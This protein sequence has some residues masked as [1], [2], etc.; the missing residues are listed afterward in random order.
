MNARSGP[1]TVS[2]TPISRV[3]AAC[4][5]GTTI[6]FYDFFIYG[7]AAA[8]VFPK[9]FFPEASPFLGTVLA[10]A[11]FG[12]GFVARPLGG[13][14]FGHFGDRLGRKK[15]LILS[16]MIMGVSTVL[17]GALPTYASVGALAPAPAGAAAARAGHRRRRRVGRRGADGRRTRT[18]AA[19]RLLRQLAPGRGPARDAAGHRSVL[20]R[21][22]A[23]RRRL[24]HLG[25]AAAVPG[26]R[27]P[28]HRRTDHPPA[29]HR[30]PRVPGGAP[31]QGRGAA[32]P[33]RGAAPSP[34]CRAPRGGR[35]PDPEHRRLRVHRLPRHLRH[36]GREGSPDNGAGRDHAQRGRQHRPASGGRCAVGP[37]RSQAD[38]HGRRDRHGR[39]DLPGVR[40]VQ[41]GQ[42]RTDVHSA[43][44]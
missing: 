10:F 14:V 28:H 39:A 20:P 38:L 27:D 9:L 31:A 35:L 3:A 8:L 15:M 16:L 44:C 21:L 30:K 36:G 26:Q 12:V 41:H 33:S 40:P 24:H 43:T 37:V 25:L 5:I 4:L 19:P 32:A 13:A 2:T 11:T 22:A 29:D 23:A 6:E 1:D 34:S 42:L 7:T 17:I 18:A